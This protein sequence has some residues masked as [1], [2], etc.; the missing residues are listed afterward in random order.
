MVVHLLIPLLFIQ[1]MFANYHLCMSP[2]QICGVASLKERHPNFTISG[3]G[4]SRVGVRHVK[5]TQIST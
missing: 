3:L 1:M 5:A 2:L 4:K